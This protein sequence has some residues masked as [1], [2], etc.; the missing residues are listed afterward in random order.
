MFFNT[1]NHAASA[2]IVKI[3]LEICSKRVELF[4]EY[5]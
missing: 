2:L 5:F 3:Q 1:T 4:F